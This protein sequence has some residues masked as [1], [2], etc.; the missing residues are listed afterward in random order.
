M[1]RNRLLPMTGSETVCASI[2][3]ADDDHSFAGRQDLNF[4]LDC[5]SETAAILLRQILHGEMDSLQ[6][7]SRNFEIARMFRSTRQHDCVEVAPQIFRRNIPSHFRS[8]NESHAFRR[9]LFQA[10]I[11]DVFFELELW[12]AVAQ[13]STDAVSFFVHDYCVAGAA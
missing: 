10:A 5:I 1:N 4:G 12:D 3:A 11:D 13:Q 6:L 7:A 9:H 8:S 2:A